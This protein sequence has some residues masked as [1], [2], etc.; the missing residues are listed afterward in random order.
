MKAKKINAKLRLSRFFSIISLGIVAL[1]CDV[2]EPDPDVLE[3]TTNVNGKAIYVL[4]NSPSI[5]D[6]NDKLQTNIPVR[7]A[8]TSQARHGNISDLGK[9]LLQYT[10]SVGNSRARDGFEF[11]VYSLNNEVI[12]RDSVIIFIENDSTNLP[13]NIYPLSDYVYG[14]AHDPVVVDVTNNDIICGGNVVVSIYKPENSFP[15]YFGQAEVVGNKVKYNPNSTFQGSDK[16]VYKIS[17]TSDTSRTAYGIV[18]LSGDSACSFRVG[19]DLYIFN[20]Y[21]ADSLIVL[22]V[23]QNDSLCDSTNQYQVNLKSAPVHG[24]ASLGQNGF[25][26]KVPVTVTFPFSDYFTYEVCID[27][28]CKTARVDIKIKKDSVSFCAFRAQ[29]DSIDISANNDTLVFLNVLLNDSTCGSLKNFRI[30][31]SPLYGTSVVVNEE[32]SYERNVQVRK[33]DTL[34]YEICNG[35]GCS[36]AVVYIKQ[37]K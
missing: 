12:K 13:C 20:Q 3:P 4:A 28:T 9:G 16:I 5:V 36:R 19:D 1:S 30:T 37:T 7:I 24:Q 18:Y 25:N 29:A 8:L 2:L 14:V 10:P 11:T 35:E 26:Y 31:K 17:T 33:D 27:A 34:E 6:L 21:A 23:F 15:P 32:I 22:P